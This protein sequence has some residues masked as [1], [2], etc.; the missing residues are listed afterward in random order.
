MYLIFFR[1]FSSFFSSLCIMYI[2]PSPPELYLAI[3][4]G[5]DKLARRTGICLDLLRLGGVI[6]HTHRIFGCP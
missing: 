2:Y 1:L 3:G 6:G 5:E 4:S